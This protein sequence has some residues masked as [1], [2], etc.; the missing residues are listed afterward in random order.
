MSPTHT[1]TRPASFMSTITMLFNT[2]LVPTS[3]P[4]PTEVQLTEM[5]ARR[6]TSTVETMSS[7]ATTSTRASTQSRGSST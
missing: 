7:A 3:P 1:S 6:S 5:P 2:P 4:P